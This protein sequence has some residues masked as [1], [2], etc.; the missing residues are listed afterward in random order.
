MLLCVL[1]LLVTAAD[2]WLTALVGLPPLIPRVRRLAALIATECR[3]CAS[4]VTEPGVI[5][6]EVID[7]DQ[8]VW[9]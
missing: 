5:N 9:R 6:A 4:S 2:A 7:T 3:T 8:E 1:V